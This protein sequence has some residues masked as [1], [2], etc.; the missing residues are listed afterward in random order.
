M[1][2]FDSLFEKLK[3]IEVTYHQLGELLSDAS[4]LSDSRRLQEI[5]KKR[6]SQEET[7]QLFDQWKSASQD[8]EDS[9]ELLKNEQ[10]EEMRAFFSDEIKRLEIEI[11]TLAKTLEILLLPRDPNDDNDI[12]LEIRAG[13][14][15]DEANIFVGDLMRM[16]LRFASEKGW[17][18]NVVGKSE[19]DI[20]GFSEVVISIKGEKVYSQLKYESGVHRVQRV[21]VTESQGRVHTSTAT[22]AVMPEVEDVNIEIRP[23]DIDIITARSG[24]AGGQNVNKVETAVRLFHK[25]S[26]IQ[27]HMTEE[28][29]QLK[30]REKAMA[31]LKIK[32]FD[33]ELQKQQKEISD[34]RRSQVGTGDRSERIRTYN[35]PQDRVT[36]H[37]IGQNFS[38]TPVING[39]VS[40]VVQQL[41]LADQQAKMEKLAESSVS[42]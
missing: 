33:I 37:R 38:L 42:S 23:E 16:Y 29:S 5:S 3:E 25:P 2:G 8:L 13:A 34:L 6:A 26:G 30:N 39:D 41:M 40:L 19:N 27:I 32:L 31:L 18:A 10:N 14:G 28:R 21:P 17:Q 36:D 7:I 12:M 1:S 24:G 4:V 15:G 22:V 20:G 11:E 35:Y 9:V